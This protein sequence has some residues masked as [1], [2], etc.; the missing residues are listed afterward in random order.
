MSK[1]LFYQFNSAIDLNYRHHFNKHGDKH[2]PETDSSHIVK[3]LSA[4]SNLKDFAHDF[5]AYIKQEYSVKQIKGITPEMCDSYIKSKYDTCSLKTIKTYQSNLLKLS[6]CANKTFNI[7]TDFSVSVDESK[8]EKTETIKQYSF[9]RQEMEKILAAPRSC[10]SLTA[11]KFAYQTGV[12][13]NTLERL[14]VRHIDFKNNEITIYKDKGNRTRVLPMSEETAKLLREQIKGK[15]PQDRVF[16][17]KKGSVNRY[18][19]RR[20]EKQNIRTTNGEI[21]SGVHSIRKLWAEEAA[22]RYDMDGKNGTKMVM[23]EL[24]H[25]QDRKDLEDTYLHSKK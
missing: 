25:S 9:T 12:R 18:L 3:S 24:G 16:A 19:R 4:K 20:C 23:S 1:S 15:N 11:L 14:E 5:S 13:V 8:I 17:V 10:D 21:K 7:R 2:N 6:K 22:E